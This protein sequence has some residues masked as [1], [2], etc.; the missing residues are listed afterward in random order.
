MR[1]NVLG[2]KWFGAELLGESVPDSPAGPPGRRGPLL[3][4][5]VPGDFSSIE[6]WEHWRRPA[7]KRRDGS[8]P[9]LAGSLCEIPADG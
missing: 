7:R 9:R 5:S 2:H 8:L 3:T 1:H 6:V 4:I